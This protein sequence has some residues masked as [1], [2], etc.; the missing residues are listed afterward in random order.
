MRPV[1]DAFA[2]A[3][4]RVCDGDEPRY[5]DV[6][7]RKAK[8]VNTAKAAK[9]TKKVG[10]KKSAKKPAASSTKAVS[11]KKK[12]KSTGKSAAAKKSGSKNSAKKKSA[13]KTKHTGK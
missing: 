10:E 12:A 7:R 8:P 9:P 3:W 6:G 1:A 5:E 13:K 2:A 11:K 4:Q